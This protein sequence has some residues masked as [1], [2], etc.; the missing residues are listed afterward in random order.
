MDIKPFEW[1]VET[2]AIQNGPYPATKC[3]LDKKSVNFEIG[4]LGLEMEIGGINDNPI[5]KQITMR[6]LG[7]SKKYLLL[8][9]KDVINIIEK[10]KV[11][12][13]YLTVAL[14]IA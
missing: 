4:K 1:T 6:I 3:F 7:L 5:N 12:R 14:L 9:I 8:P 10:I 13:R 11:G 2:D